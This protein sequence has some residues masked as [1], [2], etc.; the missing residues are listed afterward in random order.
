MIP[1]PDSFTDA[2]RSLSAVDPAAGE[3]GRVGRYRLVRELG[4]GGMG[5]VYLA[6]DERLARE[7]AVKVIRPTDEGNAKRRFVREARTAGRVH[8]DHVVPVYE[9]DEIDGVAYLV[10]PLLR[11]R[12]LAARLQDEPPPVAEV[13]RVGRELATGLVAAHELGLVHRDIKPANVWLEEPGERVKIL[14]FGLAKPADTGDETDLTDVGAAVGT[15]AYMAP[16]QA[17]GKEVDARADLFSLGCVLYRMCA[18]RPPFAGSSALAVLS[19][20]ATAVPDPV[21]RVNPTVPAPLADL[22]RRLLAKDPAHRPATARAVADE[23]AALAL[24]ETPPRPAHPRPRRRV[25]AAVGLVAAVLAAVIVAVTVRWKESPPP[26]VTAPPLPVKPATDSNRAA[27]EFVLAAGGTVTI[28]IPP[29]A[30]KSR[31]ELPPGPFRLT[32]VHLTNPAGRVTT[33]GVSAL[34]GCAGLE[35]LVLCHPELRDS[36]LEPFAATTKLEFLS[37]AECRVGAAGV[38]HF[39]GNVRL[40]TLILNQTAADDTVF[41]Q[42]AAFPDLENLSLNGTRVTKAAVQAFSAARP[43][44]RIESDSGVFGPK[45]NMD[46]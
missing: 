37:L 28:D 20:L 7:V 42:L 2:T 33:E 6:F 39:R 41:E 44:C 46:R 8:S 31:E 38:R 4:R 26:E 40:Q 21:E 45:S 18:G 9:A 34:A 43:R 5:V 29:G 11:G 24:G 15:P 25:Q 19:A 30:V 36:W 3:I 35:M 23:L 32:E 1:H 13:I 14:D 10:M 17:A 12:T 16:E 27:A 22:I